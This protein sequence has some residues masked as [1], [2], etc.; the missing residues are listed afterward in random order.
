MSKGEWETL[1]YKNSEN[2]A[3]EIGQVVLTRRTKKVVAKKMVYPAK[4]RIL[5]LILDSWYARIAIVPR[6]NGW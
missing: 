6:A 5:V 2:T 4:F 1:N 3:Y